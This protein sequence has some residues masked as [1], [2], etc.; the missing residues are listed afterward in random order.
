MNDLFLTNNTNI[1][2]LDKIKTSL[3]KCNS[4]CFTVSFI[5]KAGL[6]LLEREITEALNRGVKGKIITSTYQN[7]T[8]IA[9]LKTMLNW[10]DL[11]PNFT[12]HI[13]FNSFGD[14]GFHTKGY[15]FSYDD[16]YEFVVGSSN[17]TYF[18]L[19]KNV[20]WNVSLHSKESENSIDNAFDEF[21]KLYE[22]TLVLTREIIKNY[23]AQLEYAVEKWD[24]D[25]FNPEV[26][27]VKPNPMQAKA[28]KEIRR[29]RDLGI[30]KCLI[31]AAT[32]S[33]KTYLAAFDAK[34]YNSKKLLYI[35]HKENILIDA[36]KT[37]ETVFG[38]SKKCS[39]YSGNHSFEDADFVC[40]T[41]IMMSK[42]LDEFDPYMF[43]YICFDE[44]HHITSSSY[45]T[46]MDY[47][48]PGFVLGLTATP[49]RMDNEDV[50]ALFENNV[51]FELRL[52]DAITNNL[53][54]PFHYFAIK[55]EYVD[56]SSED[57]RIISNQISKS[58]N[59]TF[60]KEQIEKHRLAH[61]KLKCV[62]FCTSID[63]AIKMASLFNEEGYN[64][65]ALTGANNV[66]ERIKAFNALQDDASP[67]EII[68]TVDILNEG[69]DI[70]QINMVLFLR[71]TESSTIFLQQLGRGLRKFEGKEYLTVLDFI[72][73]NYER[74]IQIVSALGTLG[75]TTYSEKEYLKTLVR[76]DFKSLSI[77]GVEIF[78]DD[79]S[80]IEIIDKLDKT[81]FNKRNFLKKDYENFKSYLKLNTY[82]KHT[83]YLD[84]DI[85]PNLIRFMK[86]KI[87]TKN[88]SY[89]TFLKNIGE[90]GL[91][92]FSESQKDFIDA[93][94]E[95]LPLVRLDE[96]LIINQLLDN[97]LD[98][99]RL[100]NPDYQVSLE[101]L[102]HAINHVLKNRK[103]LKNDK[104]NV[105][106]IND[107]F[108]NYMLDL[109]TYGMKRFDTEFGSFNTKFKLMNN[110]YKEQIQMVLL[111]KSSMYQQGTQYDTK[112]GE[113]YCYVG[114]K[115]DVG[116]NLRLNYKDRFIDSK[117]F[118][119]ESVTNTTFDSTE[120]KKILNTKIV[121]LF[122][123][124][125]ENEDG[126]T[127]PF[128]YF[129]TGHF[130]NIRESNTEDKDGTKHS[131]LLTDII[132]DNEVPEEYFIDFE[133]KKKAI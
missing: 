5:K 67:L 4:F 36:K 122:I 76:T 117:T 52:R 97:S 72:G 48:K 77:P 29:N 130:K 84:S 85:A 114:L 8:D 75:K 51:P 56:Y 27:N 128:T 35:V 123:R 3:Q 65:C 131:T 82:P 20:E 6:V 1:T 14:S 57:K 21:N 17:I 80:K 81:N 9:S 40:A 22:K 55:D 108:K 43:D 11:Y 73:N 41:N 129:G 116:E 45:K 28:L 39:V 32:G 112:T 99:N 100:V 2:F 44:C 125:M 68:C 15:L 110:Y 7:F 62:A 12:C 95:L 16:S 124:K 90:E 115:K 34:N 63:H 127:L 109:L 126:I 118:E 133:I 58:I 19:I 106:V 105:D 93:V 96:Y 89:Y 46:I 50:F 13:D 47:F 69:V 92:L 64:A 37:F 98:L 87:K 111:K 38:V 91:P 104:L 83:D 74:S 53:V 49:E 18:A 132:L 121:H 78:F 101:T 30:K 79:L 60:I 61:E 103:I 88:R 86:S 107:E 59:V 54:V 26:L 71:P 119:W 113:T 94:S 70:P 42:H 120:G 24:M 25:Y 23:T 31:I 66:G 10:M 33:G 102:N